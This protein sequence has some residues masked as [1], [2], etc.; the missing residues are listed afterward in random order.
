M[1]AVYFAVVKEFIKTFTIFCVFLAL[2]IAR[3]NA[4]DSCKI[5]FN[6]QIIFNGE[7][8]EDASV[9]MPKTKKIT[10]RDCITINYNSENTNKGWMRTFYIN[11][12]DEKSLKTISM[13]KQS[14][15]VSVSATVLNEMKATKE[16]VFIYT[17][18]LPKDKKIAARI[19]VRRMFICKIEWN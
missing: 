18:S 12:T 3:A 5:F 6:K 9:V 17:T 2:T 1:K 10:N 16:P 13:S 14:G 19:R 11:G 7:V 8:D 4:N 15:S